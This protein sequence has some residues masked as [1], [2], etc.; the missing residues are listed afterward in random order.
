M[1]AL[2]RFLARHPVADTVTVA[3]VLAWRQF[4]WPGPLALVLVLAAALA[5]WRWRWSGSFSRFVSRP[6]LGKWRR[7]H[8]SRHWGAVMT[9]SGLAPMYRGRLL[10]PILRHVM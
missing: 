1:W 5:V 9:I 10:L 3:V 4:G 8:Y 6:A 2:L 7:W